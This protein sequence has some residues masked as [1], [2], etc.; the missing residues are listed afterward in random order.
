M[1]LSPQHCRDL[2]L[3][4][5]R[6]RPPPHRLPLTPPHLPPPPQ[7]PPPSSTTTTTTNWRQQYKLSSI[8]SKAVWCYGAMQL[9]HRNCRDINLNEPKPPPPPYR[10]PLTTPGSVIIAITHRTTTPHPLLQIPINAIFNHKQQSDDA[11]PTPLNLKQHHL[12][13]WKTERHFQTPNLNIHQLCL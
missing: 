11:S 9:F 1:K 7:S 10:P 6:P 12:Q 2:H 4:E 5:P 13:S 3:N 8:A